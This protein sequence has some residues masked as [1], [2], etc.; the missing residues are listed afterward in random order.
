MRQIALKLPPQDVG[1]VSAWLAAQAMPAN[2][3]AVK[4]QDIAGFRLS[5]DCGSVPQ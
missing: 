5:A 3:V 4:A 2:P 1:A